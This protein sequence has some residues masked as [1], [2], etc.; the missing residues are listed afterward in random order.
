LHWDHDAHRETDGGKGLVRRGQ[1]N[2]RTNLKQLF[3]DI[4]GSSEYG[5]ETVIQL[6]EKILH[7]VVWWNA[8]RKVSTAQKNKQPDNNT[9]NSTKLLQSQQLK[10][11]EY[12]PRKRVSQSFD[13][14]LV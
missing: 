3:K 13:I 6:C 9:N 14:S 10:G 1:G 8:I 4:N 11:E 2:T 5:R 7:R 12:H